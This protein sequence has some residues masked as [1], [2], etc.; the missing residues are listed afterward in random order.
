SE[1]AQQT[2]EALGNFRPD[3]LVVD[4]YGLDATWERLIKHRVGNVLAVDDLANRPHDC[5][6]LLDQN[7]YTD[8]ESRYSGLVPVHTRQLL[9]PRFALLRPEFRKAR[10]SLRKRDGAVRRILV[11]FGG[12]DPTGEMGKALEA[13]QNL[14]R[15]DIAVDVVVV[16]SNPRAD[17][18]HTKF[19]KMPNVTF[20][21]QVANMAELMAASDFSL[22]AGGTSH[23]ERC[24]VG[25]PTAVTVVAANQSKTTRDLAARGVVLALGSAAEDGSARYRVVLETV[26]D[27][28]GRENLHALQSA[29]LALVDGRGADRVALS[30]CD[31]PVQLRRATVEDADKVW[32]WRNHARTRKY[33]LNHEVVPHAEHLAWWNRSLN[34]VSR[35]LLIG[36]RCELE[37]GVLRYD[38]VREGKAVVSVYLD[39]DLYRQG[40][41]VALLEAG[42]K[43]MTQHCPGVS[44][45][46]AQILP[47]NEAS[48]RAFEVAGFHFRRGYWIWDTNQTKTKR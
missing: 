17:D 8:M 39:P 43:W 18:I 35:V 34:D 26:L 36:S 25:L 37:V 44:E 24:C 1:D 15:P 22:G 45:L 48:K 6:L 41:G 3:W 32:R 42:N 47:E 7:F 9:G 2:L 11:F 30:I 4:H 38:L 12:V 31:E 23:W 20:H 14:N 27:T 21:R 28:P 5:D 46:H 33:S 16:G 19:S 13:L 29:S 40:L 10:E